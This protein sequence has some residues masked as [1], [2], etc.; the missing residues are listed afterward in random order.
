M[1]SNADKTRKPLGPPPEASGISHHTPLSGIKGVIARAY[2]RR[3]LVSGF[4][5]SATA[6]IA[7]LAF[8]SPFRM[9][10]APLQIVS[11]LD[12]SSLPLYLPE[13]TPVD[14]KTPVTKLPVAELAEEKKP[15]EA[16]TK[17]ASQTATDTSAVA[18]SAPAIPQDILSEDFVSL[19]MKDLVSAVDNLGIRV[20][21]A[22]KKLTAAQ[23]EEPVATELKTDGKA[24][25][26]M[27]KAEPVPK[28]MSPDDT[29]LF[30]KLAARVA[31]AR[32]AKDA[33]AIK[34]AEAEFAMFKATLDTLIEFKIVDRKDV[35]SGFWR[36]PTDAP[37]VKQFYLVV[38]AIVDGKP[39][40]WA[41]KDA[42]TDRVVST[43]AFGLM[44]DE[45]TFAEFA[46]DKTED[47]RIDDLIVGIKPVGRITPV[48]SIQTGGQ[49][50]SGVGL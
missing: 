37:S 24:T 16:E 32:F 12:V 45:K 48:W 47:G 19:D 5:L 46:Q 30:E 39:V 13:A 35:R 11:G 9:Q 41:I 31:A 21:E 4:V 50:I 28:G 29:A 23:K 27:V 8:V 6:G 33:K 34:A 3:W 2:V 7:S 1:T 42:D 18:E 15:N 40:N 44:V 36:S 43:A 20:S 14:D 17:A 25:T 38:E 10:E 22:E 26:P 49:T